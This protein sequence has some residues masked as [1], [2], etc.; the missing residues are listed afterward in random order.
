MADGVFNVLTW[1][2]WSPDLWDF[3]LLWSFFTAIMVLAFEMAFKEKSGYEREISKRMLGATNVIAAVLGAMITLG[4]LFAGYTLERLWAMGVLPGMI[5][6]FVTGF[7]VFF[8]RRFETARE[9]PWLSFGIGAVVFLGVIGLTLGWY[10]DFLLESIVPPILLLLLA[11]MV[12]SGKGLPVGG[13]PSGGP[14]GGGGAGA[15]VDTGTGEG[16]SGF[17][18]WLG[19]KAWGGAKGVGKG[20]WGLGKKG[21]EKFGEWREMRK[22]L[23]AGEQL[24]EQQE[25]Q[26]QTVV[27]N[28]ANDAAQVQ[29]LRQ[30]VGGLPAS[31]FGK[32][33]IELRQQGQT[34]EQIMATLVPEVKR[35]RPKFGDKAAQAFVRKL[36]E[37][38]AAKDQLLSVDEVAMKKG[39]EALEGLK[40]SRK[41]YVQWL[42]NLKRLVAVLRDLPG[43]YKALD[44]S[45]RR[46]GS[47]MQALQ[48]RAK[49]ANATDLVQRCNDAM[50]KLQAEQVQFEREVKQNMQAEQ[51]ELGI[52]TQYATKLE[53]AL[54]GLDELFATVDRNLK[55]LETHQTLNFA[56]ACERNLGQ[57]E[58]RL[59]QAASVLQNNQGLHQTLKQVFKRVSGAIE[60]HEEH[61]SEQTEEVNRIGEELNRAA[62]VGEQ[63]DEAVEAVARFLQD[64]RWND[65]KTLV[66]GIERNRQAQ[67]LTMEE[68]NKELMGNFRKMAYHIAGLNEHL[69]KASA[70]PKVKNIRGT[71]WTRFERNVALITARL[72]KAKTDDDVVK[73]VGMF[74]DRVGKAQWS[75]QLNAIEGA[76]RAVLQQSARKKSPPVKRAAA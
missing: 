15:D 30:F 71:I 6:L 45:F 39:R 28:A 53:Q 51:S 5:A 61:L 14:S 44:E 58:Q 67:Q 4:M 34:D 54:A 29:Q 8:V 63:K 50:A 69:K 2:S 11:G 25:K 19:G 64:S 41:G 13:G 35:Q 75:K 1:Y 65:L 62:A 9:N 43:K 21:K 7:V 60:R 38:M 22:L 76:L 12:L 3:V 17:W 57:L 36:L 16:K 55:D 70:I 47:A 18:G 27:R 40:K 26:E 32:R 48:N 68:R 37:R 59:S 20:A 52:F 23:K 66:D 10:G 24:T 56:R 49:R 72:R 74:L 46:I 42:N 31:P 33:A 73:G